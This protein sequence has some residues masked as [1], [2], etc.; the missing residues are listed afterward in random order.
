MKTFLQRMTLLS[1]KLGVFKGDH[2]VR[3][4]AVFTPIDLADSEKH[5]FLLS[6]FHAR[7][8]A[9]QAVPVQVSA[10]HRRGVGHVGVH[11][12]DE[13]DLLESQIQDFLLLALGAGMLDRAQMLDVRKLACF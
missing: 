10:Q 9:E 1:G 4:G 6:R 3:G 8:A 13:A 5:Y 11:I 12:G 2:A 7:F